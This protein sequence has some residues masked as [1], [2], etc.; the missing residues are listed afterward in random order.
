MK[1]IKFVMG[2]GT[3]WSK[4]AKLFTNRTEHNVKNRFFSIL[5]HSTIL[6]I[7]K[8]KK[9]GNYRNKE[10]LVSILS[11]LSQQKTKEEYHD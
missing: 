9:L 10:M 7:R 3:K 5:S 2:N 11:N 8:I 4:L 6:T 1:I